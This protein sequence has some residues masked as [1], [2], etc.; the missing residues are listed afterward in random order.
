M[1]ANKSAAGMA[2]ANDPFASLAVGLNEDA[3]A[4]RKRQPEIVDDNP[5]DINDGLSPVTA[6]LED[7]AKQFVFDSKTLSGDLATAM[8]TL[9]RERPKPWSA[10]SAGE[11]SDVVAALNEAAETFVGKAVVAIATEDRPTVRGKVMSFNDTGDKAKMVLEIKDASLTDMMS[12]HAV[13]RKDVV[14]VLADGGDH[15]ARGGDDLIE[16]DQAD[17]DFDADGD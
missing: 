17:I 7:M 11:Q 2:G 15:I 13:L 8:I 12:I 4:E 5:L 10:M 6:A 14:V 1:A 16:A 9:F 3:K